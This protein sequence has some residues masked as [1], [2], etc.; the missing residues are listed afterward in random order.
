MTGLRVERGGR[1]RFSTG[2]G[3]GPG[4]Y[5]GLRLPF[6][7]GAVFGGV[8]AAH[9]AIP[10][11]PGSATGREMARVSRRGASWS[12]QTM[13]GVWLMGDRGQRVGRT[14]PGAVPGLTMDGL[15]PSEALH[16]LAAAAVCRGLLRATGA[17]VGLPGPAARARRELGA[18]RR[19]LRPRADGDG[20]M[21]ATRVSVVI[22]AY[23]E[24]QQI[25]PTLVSVLRACERLERC[26]ARAEVLVVDNDSSDGTR[27]ALGKLCGRGDALERCSRNAARPGLATAGRAASSATCWSS[28]TPTR[29]LPENALSRVLAH[30]R[31]RT[32]RL[33]GIGRLGRLDGGLR[34]YCWWFFWGQVRRAA[35]GAGQGDAGVHVLHARSVRPAGRVRRARGDRRGVADPGRHLAA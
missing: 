20:Q 22:P 25:G 4:L 34:A 15:H 8:G 33:A 13:V 11:G 26:G 17:G 24:E 2:V 7:A 27:A 35:A 18:A 14:C 21:R 6:E 16:G 1:S 19:P 9:P 5:D 30:L 10:G 12:L 32:G 3:R 23:N 31:R 29:R 28:L